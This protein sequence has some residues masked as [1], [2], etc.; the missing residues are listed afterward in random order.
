MS[1][2]TQWLYRVV[3]LLCGNCGRRPGTWCTYRPS[4][5][6][7]ARAAT[8]FEAMGIASRNE[9]VTRSVACVMRNSSQSGARPQ[10][11]MHP[12]WRVPTSCALQ[13][14]R[15][16]LCCV[17]ASSDNAVCRDRQVQRRMLH[18]GTWPK[19]CLPSRTQTLSRT[20]S[21]LR[22]W[23]VLQKMYHTALYEHGFG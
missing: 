4:D 22:T 11:V 18:H 20:W 3:A 15:V 21:R 16:A 5:P 19:K 23:Y 8:L 6:I 1:L 2:Q 10:D 7:T 9:C 14:D 13:Q 12:S 17:P